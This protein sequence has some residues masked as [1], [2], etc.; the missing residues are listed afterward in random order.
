MDVAAPLV[1][2]S[3]PACMSPAAEVPRLT[4]AVVRTSTV[5]TAGRIVRRTTVM[6]LF[7]E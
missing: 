7:S 1:V 5:A 4:Q 3:W 6:M 2:M